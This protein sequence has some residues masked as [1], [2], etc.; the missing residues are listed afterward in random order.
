L[1]PCVRLADDAALKLKYVG[2][3]AEWAQFSV[4][5]AL[6][7]PIERSEIEIVVSLQKA[8]LIHGVVIDP[9]GHPL[10][11]AGIYHAGNAPLTHSDDNGLFTVPLLEPRQLFVCKDGYE[12][13]CLE[14]QLEAAARNDNPLTVI[15]AQSNGRIAGRVVLHDGTPLRNH[16]VDLYPTRTGDSSLS[17]GSQL[18]LI[19]G[20]QG[21]FVLEIQPKSG[22]WG[23][24]SR[25]GVV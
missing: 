1:F 6:S 18:G 11:G 17:L 5:E 2:V 8:P 14:E 21:E 3:I 24:I 22:F 12:M 10:A 23:S 16:V 4:Y 13:V 15:L 25:A 7:F 20:D 9:A 19:L